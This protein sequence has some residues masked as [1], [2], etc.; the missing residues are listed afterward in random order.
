MSNEPI[1]IRS[2]DTSPEGRSNS[3]KLFCEIREFI[4]RLIRNEAFTLI[5]GRT[6]DAAQLILAQLA[7]GD[8]KMAP[9]SA[10]PDLCAAVKALIDEIAATTG[11]SETAACTQGYAALAK[12][13]GEKP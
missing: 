7:H 2:W 11:H 13:R 4:A 6:E 3:S 10:V 9:E 5:G 8:Y 12:A 1:V